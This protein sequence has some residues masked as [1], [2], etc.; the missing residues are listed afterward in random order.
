MVRA[1][2]QPPVSI[3]CMLKEYGLSVFTPLI[4][5]SLD[6]GLLPW[7]RGL[8]GDIKPTSSSG[9]KN[10]AQTATRRANYVVAL[11]AVAESISVYKQGY[12]RAGE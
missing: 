12:V 3:L 10:R 8:L 7:D 1:E 5:L 2:T 6:H 9:T 4:S 11:I